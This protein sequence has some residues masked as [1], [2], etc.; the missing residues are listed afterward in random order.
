ME[1]QPKRGRGRPK[2]SKNKKSADGHAG[3]DTLPSPPRDALPT[4]NPRT[5][6]EAIDL[7]FEGDLMDEE[8][9]KQLKEDD[10]HIRQTMEIR[11]PFS[12][13]DPFIETQATFGAGATRPNPLNISSK[14]EQADLASGETRSTH[15]KQID[16][17]TVGLMRLGYETLL[18][19][20]DSFSK[21]KVPGKRMVEI[22]ESDQDMKKALD[23][24]LRE[25]AERYDL[26]QY[27]GPQ[28]KLILLTMG[29]FVMAKASTA[30]LE[31]QTHS[32]ARPSFY[33]HET[34]SSE[35]VAS[36]GPKRVK[37]D[38]PPQNFSD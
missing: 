36:S 9:E 14:L 2:G 20:G 22:L 15:Q 28:N 27:L 3:E 35:S 6:P 7:S 23:D 17:G 25:L 29:L 24:S 38:L 10:E 5:E 4:L 18:K 30:G 33:A 12:P 21:G 32:E 11:E 34:S 26:Q 1:I 8:F 13:K 31:Q 37:L 19:A 16:R